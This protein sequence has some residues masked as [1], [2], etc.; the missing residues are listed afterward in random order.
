MGCTG[1]AFTFCWVFHT[2]QLQTRGLFHPPAVPV[3]TLVLSAAD[4]LI[5]VYYVLW[6]SHFWVKQ[7][8]KTDKWVAELQPVPR[9][10]HFCFVLTKQT[11]N[12]PWNVVKQPW[13]SA[14]PSLISFHK[15]RQPEPKA[16][17][18]LCWVKGNFFFLWCVCQGLPA[19][20]N[21]K[22]QR[23]R[24]DFRTAP[25]RQLNGD[26]NLSVCHRPATL[27]PSESASCWINTDASQHDRGAA[28]QPVKGP[29][30]PTQ[31]GMHRW[32]TRWPK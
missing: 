24:P 7:E 4:M 29:T 1:F 15:E 14:F 31:F 18:I 9:V 6:F 20:S 11:V 19:W 27:G 21:E 12:C 8:R 30:G 25:A 2:L 3:S 10:N 13:N 22:R 5:I 26:A 32:G 17:H 23:G 16:P 28:F